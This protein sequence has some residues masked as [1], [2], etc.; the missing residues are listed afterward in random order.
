[1]EK[2]IHKA[3]YSNKNA[4]IENEN[5]RMNPNLINISKSM[6]LILRHKAKDFGLDI[7]PSGFIKLEDLL[8]VNIIKR[9]KV[10]LEMVKE[11]VAND[12]KQR[13]ILENRP[14]YYIKASQGHSMKEVNNSEALQPLE[15]Y[16]NYPCVVHGTFADSWEKILKTGLNKMS[17]NCIRKKSNKFIAVFLKCF[18]L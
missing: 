12:N 3:Q 18:Y 7:E 10:N 9:R 13:F 15:D 1:M 4:N 17:R 6:S 11:I 5:K 2:H 14:P 8:N 16:W